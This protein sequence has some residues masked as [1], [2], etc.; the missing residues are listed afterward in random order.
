MSPESEKEI[1]SSEEKKSDATK[2][3]STEKDDSTDT[4]EVVQISDVFLNLDMKQPS[5]MKAQEKKSPV[6]S[7][8]EDDFERDENDTDGF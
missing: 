5:Y 4:D 8:D 2:E 7:N 1:A 6:E 3:D